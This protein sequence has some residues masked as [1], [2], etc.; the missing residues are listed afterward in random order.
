MRTRDST[1]T[2]PISSNLKLW[3]GKK[4][5]K[6]HRFRKEHKNRVPKVSQHSPWVTQ[7]SSTRGSPDGKPPNTL[8]QNTADWP[9]ENTWQS[10]EEGNT[11][12]KMCGYEEDDLLRLLVTTSAS[13]S[14]LTAYLF[15]GGGL[16]RLKV[17]GSSEALWPLQTLKSARLPGQGFPF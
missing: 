16:D 4:W 8:P 9:R 7:F 14:M 3:L 10:H 12:G 2:L 1:L 13:I 11:K 17:T 6:N 15:M 5:R